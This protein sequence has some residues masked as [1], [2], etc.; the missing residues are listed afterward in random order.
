MRPVL[1]FDGDCGFCTSSAGLIRRWIRPRCDIQPWQ[2]LDLSALR[3]SPEDCQE[4]V[5]YV[6]ATGEVMSGSRAITAMLR[7]A[8]VPW[9]LVGRVLDLPAI[10]VVADHAYRWVARNR[11]RLPGSTPACAAISR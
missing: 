10:A 4:A 2:F 8:P 1:V 9:P 11:H 3:L 7:T 6:A 5:Q